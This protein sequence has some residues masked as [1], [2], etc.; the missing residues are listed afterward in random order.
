MIS[1]TTFPYICYHHLFLL[2]TNYSLAF[3]PWKFLNYSRCTKP[4]DVRRNLLSNNNNNNNNNMYP[5]KKKKK[6]KEKRGD[7]VKSEYY[8]KRP[9]SE[10]FKRHF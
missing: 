8:Q 7:F 4:G 10:Y 3:Q 6:R 5:T 9:Q 2:Y 1:K